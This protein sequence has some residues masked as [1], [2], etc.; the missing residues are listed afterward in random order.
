MLLKTK[1]LFYIGLL[2]IASCKSNSDEKQPPD[3]PVVTESKR[4]IVTVDMQSVNLII[5]SSTTDKV[6][7]IKKYNDK[8]VTY[9][10]TITDDEI[11]I[12]SKGKSAFVSDAGK[13]EIQVPKNCVIECKLMSGSATINKISC[14]SIDVSSMSGNLK[15]KNIATKRAKFKSMSGNVSYRGKIENGNTTLSSMSGNVNIILNKESN[16]KLELSSESANV[17]F[18]DEM[19]K[20]NPSVKTLKEGVGFLSGHSI[21]GDVECATE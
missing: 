14:S 20:Q 18:D 9:E 3:A 7:I 2:I 6:N 19:Q 21:S 1:H 13:I 11:D 8:E 5:D 4:I 12:V 16:V 10:E 17:L 15:I